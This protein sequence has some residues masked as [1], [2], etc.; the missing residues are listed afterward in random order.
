MLKSVVTLGQGVTKGLPEASATRDPIEL[1]GEWFEEAK[2]SGILLP[3]SASLATATKEAIP[4][5][6]MVLLK[7]FGTN[8]FIFYT[9]YGSRKAREIDENPS[10]SLLMHWVTLQR[11][12][13][14]EGEA[15]RISLT[16]S[17]AYFHTRSRGSQIGAWASRQS[18]VL[19]EPLIL[20]NRFSEIEDRFKKQEI[21]LPPFWGGYRL[22]P[23]RIEF[24]QGR[25]NRLHDRL[26][27]TRSGSGWSTERLYP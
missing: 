4:S 3:E 26:V 14:F 6:R 11:Q 1:F 10:V 9:N 5:S 27:F 19:A 8:G 15:K 22:V 7:Q 13:R 2:K 25:L 12:V 18:D 16:E 24:W 17:E 20:Q 21:P 23:R